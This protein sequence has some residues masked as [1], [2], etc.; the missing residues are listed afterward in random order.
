MLLTPEMVVLTSRVISPV[1]RKLNS[2]KSLNLGGLKRGEPTA[3]PRPALTYLEKEVL[4]YID[5]HGEE[6]SVPKASEELGLS[7]ARLRAK[8]SAS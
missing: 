3:P 5:K 7:E 1:R 2:G 8:R 6:I 4:D